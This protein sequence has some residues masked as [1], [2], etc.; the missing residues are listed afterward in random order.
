[1]E[2]ITA[3]EGM[4]LTQKEVENEGNRVFAISLYLADNDSPDNWREATQQ[5]CYDWQREQEEG[6][7]E[8]LNVNE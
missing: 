3:K 2:K 6:D 4:Y 1:M 7:N 8:K 5:E